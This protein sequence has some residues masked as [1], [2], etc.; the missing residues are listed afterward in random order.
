MGKFS[1]IAHLVETGNK[2]ELIHEVGSIARA[3]GRTCEE[4]ADGFIDAHREMR[5]NRDNPAYIKLNEIH[6][7][8]I[9]ENEDESLA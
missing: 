6:D 7:E 3:T 9:K 2:K 5:N 4:V 8:I 1:Y